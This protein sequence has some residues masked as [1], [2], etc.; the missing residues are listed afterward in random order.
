[1][2]S[3]TERFDALQE[4]QL[5]LY[6]AGSDK[7]EDQIL[8]WEINRQENVL[9]YFARQKGL[10]R[11]GLQPV[12]P[13]SVSEQ[14][15]KQAIAMSLHLKS[16]KESEFGREPW[17]LQ[18]TSFE[19]FN[20]PP[21][22]TFKKGA[23]TVDVYYDE[24]QDNYFPYTAWTFIYYQNGDN[25]WHKVEGQC[26]YEGLYYITADNEKI[27]YVQFNKDAARFSRSGLWT[28]KYKNREISSTSV[29]STSGNVAGP[30]G[31][32]NITKTTRS[33]GDPLG[34]KK[35]RRRQRESSSSPTR[36]LRPRTS[37]SDGDHDSSSSGRRVYR[38]RRRE[39]ESAAR[40]REQRRT[41]A[42]PYVPTPD[43]VGSRH[44]SLERTGYTRLGRLQAE[45]WDPYVLLLK[46]PANTL[47]CYR[48]RLKSK[49]QSS[50]V[51]IST[52]FSWVG[53][54]IERIGQ[55]RMLIAFRSSTERHHFLKTVILPKGTSYSFGNLDSL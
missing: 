51:S 42:D 36:R 8:F 34:S 3:L 43:A 49:H 53:E 10:S 20:S 39:R 29:T 44:R 6:E 1:M 33:S 21:Q 54:G 41:T 17:T 16:L 35:E 55:P 30:A 28:V 4:N 14:K 12:P 5:Q 31:D 24:D 9:L 23:F 15:A 25:V 38:R 11:I 26:D 40:R 37:Q 19:L 22:N 18:D 2:E 13:L 50:I 48:H 27:Y 52:V 45:A 32:P 47:K 7:I 46:G